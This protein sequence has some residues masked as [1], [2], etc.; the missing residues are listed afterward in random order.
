MIIHPIGFL[1]DHMEVLYDLD[2]EAMHLCEELG[3]R[4]F[5]RGPWVRI[6]GSSGCFAS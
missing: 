4:W 6:A 3:L 2:E 5:A 1:S